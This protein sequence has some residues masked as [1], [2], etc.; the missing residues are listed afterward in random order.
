M[1]LIKSLYGP[2]LSLLLVIPLHLGFA[3]D[4]SEVNININMIVS[5]TTSTSTYYY[6]CKTCQS[7]IFSAHLYQLR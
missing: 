4:A 5:I 2:F 6:Y 1:N 3:S 7:I